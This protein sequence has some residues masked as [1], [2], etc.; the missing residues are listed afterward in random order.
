MKI[1]LDVSTR[2]ILRNYSEGVDKW[3]STSGKGGTMKGILR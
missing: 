2:S 3:F 1:L